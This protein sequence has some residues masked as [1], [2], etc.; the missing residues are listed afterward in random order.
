MI[1]K[2]NQDNIYLLLPSK[3]SWLAAML[4]EDK[5]ISLV[6]AIKQVYASKL[7][8]KLQDESTKMWHLGPVDLYKELQGEC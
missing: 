3:V 7:Y 6:A 1:G 5:G 2:I 8:Q 4:A